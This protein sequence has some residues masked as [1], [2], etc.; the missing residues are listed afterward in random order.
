[1]VFRT[2]GTTEYASGIDG[3]A[4]VWMY[5]GDAASNRRMFLNTSGQLWC[6]NYGW[7]HDKF[8]YKGGTGGQ[9]FSANTIYIGNSTTRGLRAVSGNYGTVQTTGG[10][11]GN[12]E[13]YSINGRYVFMSA[14]N[15]QCGI[16]NDLDNEWMAHFNRNGDAQI[17]YNGASKLQTRSDGVNV[18][19]DLLVGRVGYGNDIGYRIEKS[20]GDYM[21][22]T[23]QGSRG[24]WGGYNI[25]NQWGLMAHTN[26]GTCGIYNDQENEWGLECHR[27]GYTYIHW[28]GAWKMRTESY[29]IYV[30]NDLYVSRVGYGHDINYRIEKSGGDYMTVT[31]HGSRRSWGGYNIQNQWGL[32]AHTDGGTCGIYNDIDN[33]W[34]MYCSRGS[35]TRLFYNNGEK[36]RTEDWGA[37]VLGNLHVDGYGWFSDRADRHGSLSYDFSSKECYV[38]NWVRTK[39]N[40]G[41]YWESPS[42]G[43]GWHIFP[44][45][46]ND[47]YLRT[48]SSNGGICGTIN[49]DTPRGYVHWT[50]S[51]EIG[52]L[53]NSRNWCLRMDGSNNCQVY[54]RMHATGYVHTY[55]TARYYNGT[56]GN[57]THTA[58]RPISIY[59]EHHMRCM[60]LQVTSDRR[61]KTDIADVNDDSALELLR[62]IQPK[63]YGYVD[64][65]QKGTKQ[66]YGFIAQEIKELIPEAVDVSEGDLPNIYKYATIDIKN[67]YITI[68]DFDTSNLNQT[69]S[70]IYVDANDKRQTLKI[71][72]VLNSTQLEIEENLEELVETL[73]TSELE[74]Y[75]FTG[76]IFIWGQRVDDFH[77]LQKSAV[78]TVAT[79]ALQEVDRQLQAEKLKTARLEER[80]ASLEEILVRNGLV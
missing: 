70:I 3:Y 43:A 49:N 45:D 18:T 56:G 31:T 30:N 7:L 42:N 61:I 77:H 54:G 74:E 59:A 75:E 22:V 29:G 71:K 32:M 9:N 76:E 65:M 46:Q 73:G 66:V 13:G 63:K 72:S 11:A 8:A 41:H 21:T 44:R 79:A 57:S 40:T 50:T 34:G 78:F 53:N 48:G 55:M 4:F 15:N 2:D 16:F 17:Y 24:S 26:G 67:N 6:S 47:M 23:T 33:H 52:F 36:F 28:N 39:G 80:L 69:E 19:G 10:G 20:G 14:D 37:R 1:M 35:H 68:E 27:N 60:E 64:T 51:N 5:G 38:Q 25:Q 62:K 58:T 12:W